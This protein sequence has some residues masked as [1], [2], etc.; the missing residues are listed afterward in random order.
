MTSE[1]FVLWLSGFVELQNSDTINKKQWGLIKET[2]T[3]A[4]EDMI[5]DDLSVFLGDDE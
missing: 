5:F 1:E 4:R 2:L 3:E